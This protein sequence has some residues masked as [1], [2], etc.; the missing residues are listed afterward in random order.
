MSQ[1]EQE[2]ICRKLLIPLDKA[3]WSEDRF[4]D[5]ITERKRL[6]LDTAGIKGILGQ[7]NNDNEDEED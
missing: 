7:I 1:E 6:I 4:E 5:F 2:H 3:L